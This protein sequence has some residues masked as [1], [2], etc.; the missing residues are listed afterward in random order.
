MRCFGE[1]AVSAD[2]ERDCRD[3]AERLRL[4]PREDQR[5]IVALHRSVANDPKVTKANRDEARRR[6]DALEKL[7]RLAR[8]KRRRR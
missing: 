2:W 3:E 7:L 4:L 6:A 1:Q 5:A 8:R